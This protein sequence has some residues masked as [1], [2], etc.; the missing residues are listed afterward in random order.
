[1]TQEQYETI[2][3]AALSMKR[4]KFAM[5]EAL[6]LDIPDTGHGGEGDGSVN[7]AL[8]EVAEQIV[9]MGGDDIAV[10][11]LRKM[12]HTALWVQASTT[13]GTSFEWRE[14]SS[15]TAHRRAYEGGMEWALFAR[16][17]RTTRDVQKALGNKASV[18]S[19]SAKVEEMTTTERVDMARAL[20]AADPDVVTEAATEQH[21]EAIKTATKKV[22]TPDKGHK[23][24]S[25]SDEMTRQLAALQD[26]I[27]RNVTFTGLITTRWSKELAEL[28]G[29]V[30]QT[31]KDA[32]VESLQGTVDLYLTMIEEL[33]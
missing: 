8:E 13:G 33:S 11:T 29:F 3:R 17:P 16:M 30:Q 21:K 25:K 15:F 22:A 24:P 20:A 6:V 4:S 28:G 31:N 12:R 2:I 23:V 14:G 5:A 27:S 10:G 1:M 26:V 18:G 19:T 9:N 7:A 32:I